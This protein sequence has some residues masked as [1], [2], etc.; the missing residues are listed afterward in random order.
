VVAAVTA[1]AATARAAWRQAVRRFKGHVLRDPTERAAARWFKRRGDQT[2]RLNYPLDA[3]SVVVDCG[4]YEGD[5]AAEI[6]ARFGCCVFVFEPVQAHGQTLRQRFT[7]NAQVQVL[8]FGLH[9]RD[10]QAHMTL[11]GDAS[12]HAG[13]APGPAGGAIE[14]VQLRDVAAVLPELGIDH[15]ALMK[16]NIE[17]GEFE[18]IERLIDSGWVSRI[19]HLQVQFHRFVPDAERRRH[20]LR[21]R[22]R[23]TH[24]ERYNFEFIWESWQRR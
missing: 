2:L 4:G 23:A 19:D 5:W 12:S 1:L 10:A 20:A 24:V 17:G 7:A 21:E 3:S 13:P 11:A 14:L 15:V 6:H 22:L 18:L 9:S 16:V 8:A